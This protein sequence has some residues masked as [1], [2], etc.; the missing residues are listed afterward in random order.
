MRMDLSGKHAFRTFS[1]RDFGYTARMFWGNGY[2]SVD[3]T[4]DVGPRE[5]DLF[6]AHVKRSGRTALAHLRLALKI[7]AWFAPVSL[8]DGCHPTHDEIASR[9]GCETGSLIY[10][11]CVARSNRIWR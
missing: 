9:N 5:R 6:L 2:G 3:M 8:R 1:K 7:F 11:P 4:K 10:P